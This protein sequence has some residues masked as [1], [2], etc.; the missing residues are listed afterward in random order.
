MDVL[1]RDDLP[2][3]QS[4]PEFQ[5]LFPDEA[6]CAG[7]ME[8]ARWGGRVRLSALPCR[9]RA[10]SH[11]HASRCPALPLF[12]PTSMSSRSALTGASTHSTPSAPC[13]GSLAMS[14]RLPST[15]SIRG[16]GCTLHVV[17]E[18]VN[19]IGKIESSPGRSRY[20]YYEKLEKS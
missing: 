17:G 11:R 1:Q 18:C 12:K 10:L 3:P 20:C 2:F 15:N 16:N 8:K 14:A 9:R 6:A 7:Y 13:S 5:Q 19:R 4:L